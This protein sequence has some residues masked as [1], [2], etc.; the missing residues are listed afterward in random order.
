MAEWVTGTVTDVK[1]WTNS[2]C[3]LKVNAQ[4]SP[5]KAGQFTK[6]ALNINGERVQRAYSYV[7]AP[8]SDDLEFYLVKVPQGKLSPLLYDLNLGDELL[9]VNQAT[10]FFVLAEIPTCHTL[11][12][13]ATGTGLSPYLSI[14]QNGQDLARFE[15][16]ILVYAVRYATDLSYLP[17]MKQLELHYRGKL[18]TVTIISREKA[19]GS[20]Y[21]RIPQLISSGALEHEAGHLF[22]PQQSHV[23]LCGNPQMISE[24]RTLLIE[25]RAMQK[26]LRRQ[27]GHITSE[28]Y[29]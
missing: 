24:T 21:G 2:L 10:G 12:M 8:N 4:V 13:I 28:N 9:L 11:W 15:K 14:L 17:L 3:S 7:N 1:R 6:L 20:L 27:P 5:F 18:T 26:H 29:W 16:L 22:N 19:Q 23:M 25:S